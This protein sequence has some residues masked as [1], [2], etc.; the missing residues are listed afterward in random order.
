M[1]NHSFKWLL[2]IWNLAFTQSG[3]GW[4]VRFIFG[5]FQC[6]MAHHNSYKGW[7]QEELSRPQPSWVI[8]IFNKSLSCIWRLVACDMFLIE[9]CN[10]CPV[11]KKLYAEECVSLMCDLSRRTLW[12]Q[13]RW[14]QGW[15]LTAADTTLATLSACWLVW[16]KWPLE[17]FV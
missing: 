11:S 3:T 1:W 5:L 2:K 14:L 10:I 12:G 16:I 7:N 9:T 15:H 4:N 6:N 8:K 13:T 17:H